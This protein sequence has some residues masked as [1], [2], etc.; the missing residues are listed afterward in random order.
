MPTAGEANDVLLQTMPQ[1]GLGYSGAAFEVGE[2][3]EV[4]LVKVSVDLG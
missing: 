3:V 1:S 4:L 2:E